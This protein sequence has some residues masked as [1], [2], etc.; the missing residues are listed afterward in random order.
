M[1]QYSIFRNGAQL[2]KLQEEDQPLKWECGYGKIKFTEI[3]CEGK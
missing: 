3:Y 2:V 1:I